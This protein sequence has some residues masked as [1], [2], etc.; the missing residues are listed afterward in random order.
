MHPAGGLYIS[1]VLHQAFIAVDESGTEAAAATAVIMDEFGIPAAPAEFTVDR[2][3][4]FFIRDRSGLLLF[5]GQ[6]TD[7]AV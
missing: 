4:L 3:F 1:D 5:T 6:V 7:P 2:P